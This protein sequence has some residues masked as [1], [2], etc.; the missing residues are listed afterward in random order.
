VKI[1]L[2][3]LAESIDKTD[4]EDPDIDLAK[5]TSIAESLLRARRKKESE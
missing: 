1:V 2:A 5:R 4:N 3:F